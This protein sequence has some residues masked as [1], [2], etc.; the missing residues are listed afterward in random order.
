LGPRSPIALPRSSARSSLSIGRLPNSTLNPSRSITGAD[1][2]TSGIFGKTA[3]AGAGS[4][5]SCSALFIELL[6]QYSTLFA[7]HL[8][9]AFA[10]DQPA[11]LQLPLCA[12]FFPE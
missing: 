9:P 10:E 7:D 2:T 1:G 11:L 4:E 8:A 12:S 6:A 3:I 5:V